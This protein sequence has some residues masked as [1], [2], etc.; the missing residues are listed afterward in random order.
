MTEDQD[1]PLFREAHRR[2]DDVD[3]ADTPAARR[4]AWARFVPSALVAFA[5]GILRD[6][7]MTGTAVFSVLLV[8]IGALSG[9]PVATVAFVVV[10]VLGAALILLVWRRRWSVGGQ[11]LA[12]LGVLA[13][14][15]LAI[16]LFGQR[17]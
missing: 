11:W 3:R 13:F 17:L 10:G 1:G 15:I 4:K 12:T 6:W 8:V 9:D 2:A 14:N 7:A 5:E 16:I